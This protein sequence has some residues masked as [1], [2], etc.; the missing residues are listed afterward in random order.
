[1]G[2]NTLAL[3]QVLSAVFGFVGKWS[4]ELQHNRAPYVLRYLLCRLYDQGRGNLMGSQIVLAQGTIGRKLG[5]SRQWV[6]ILLAR[7]ADAGW[8]ECYSPVLADGMRGSTIFRVG[9][10]LKRLLVMLIKSKTPKR[11]VTSDAKPR[12]QFSPSKEEKTLLQT[13]KKENEMP[14]P[15]L[16]ARIP[17]LRTWLERGES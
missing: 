4:P 10:Q 1:M 3:D 12:W 8:L 15:E 2:G 7:L 6:G 5:L 9:R 16:L 17:L 11:P 13:R 14:K